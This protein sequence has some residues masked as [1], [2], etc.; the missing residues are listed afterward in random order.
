[1]SYNL[2]IRKLE[3]FKDEYKNCIFIS[4]IKYT[5]QF[6][7][8][9]K[10]RTVILIYTKFF[11]KRVIYLDNKQ[12]Y[13]SSKYTYNFN[14]SFPIEFHNITITQKDYFYTLK[15]NNI[16]FNNILNDLKLKKF[17]ILEDTYKE[18]QKEKKLKQLKKRKNRLLL[19]AINNFNKKDKIHEINLSQDEKKSKKEEKEEKEEESNEDEDSNTIHQSFEIHRKISSI[20]NNGLNNINNINNS[21]LNYNNKSVS[22]IS[23]TS[24]KIFKD[25]NSFWYK[26]NNN[27]NNKSFFNYKK[28]SF[29]SLKKNKKNKKNKFNL[30]EKAKFKTYENMNS[31]LNEM[32]DFDLLENGLNASGERNGNIFRNNLYSSN[33]RSFFDKGSLT[34]QSN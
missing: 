34:T 26:D 23:D 31:S 5:W 22:K 27:N 28:K 18:K 14:F 9:N 10:P 2:N 21:S 33:N 4:N 7:L 15:I 30:S 24:N 3:F 11:G 16:S 1:M 32:I 19:E 13:N 20:I 17:N 25:K 12:I 29:K 8:D 6:I